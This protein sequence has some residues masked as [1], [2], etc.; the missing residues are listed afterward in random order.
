LDHRRGDRR[1]GAEG[2]QYLADADPLAIMAGEVDRRQFDLA[3]RHSQMLR[4]V[5]LAAHLDRDLFHTAIGVLDVDD[6]LRARL[7]VQTQPDQC[8]P[9]VAFAHN[10]D[11]LVVETDLRR[12]F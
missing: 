7:P 3:L 1:L 2:A 6:E 8:D 12:L 11:A 4:C 10:Q 5:L 9:F